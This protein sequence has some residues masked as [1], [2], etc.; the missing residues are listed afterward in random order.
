MNTLIKHQ[1][2]EQDGKPA[3]AVIPYEDFLKLSRIYEENRDD[4]DVWIPHEVVKAN[5]LNDVP[6]IRAWR[7]HLGLT[8]REVAER[9]GMSQP[10]YAKLERPDARPRRSTIK[11]IAD[12]MEL[13]VE[14]VAD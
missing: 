6:L 13:K 2:I 1:I 4:S 5:A 11:K 14:Q 10:A 3:F 12:A 7:E 9:A 8:Q